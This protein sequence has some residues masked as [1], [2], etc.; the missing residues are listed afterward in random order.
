MAQVTSALRCPSEAL[1]MAVGVLQAGGTVVLP[2]DTVYGVGAAASIPEATRVLFALKDRSD[3]Q[4]LAVLVA[5]TA[6]ALELVDPAAIDDRV[7]AWMGRWWPGPLTLVLPRSEVARGLELGGRPDTVGV[8]CPDS[9]F[10]RALAAQVGPIATT[11]ANRHGEP[12]ATEA[13]AAA[14]SL[15]GLVDLVVDGGPSGTVASTVVDVC[16]P[17]PKVLREGTVS[18]ADLGLSSL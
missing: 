17:T 12:T 7:Q 2:T 16:G 10:V 1:T 14:A 13:G 3:A 5:D 8:R 18:A 9:A 15:D 4:P 6:Q 11:S